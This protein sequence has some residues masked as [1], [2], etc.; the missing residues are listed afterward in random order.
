MKIHDLSGKK[1]SYGFIYV[2]SKDVKYYEMAKYSCQSLRDYYPDAHI[3]LFTHEK[4]LDGEEHGLFDSV[5]TDIPVHYRTKMWCM[6]R[7]PYEKTVYID[8]DSFV[9][10][11]DIRTIHNFLDE[12]DMFFTPVEAYTTANIKWAW[13][14]KQQTEVPKYHGAVCG[15]NKTDLNIDFMQTWYD[16]Y[17]KQVCD[18]EWPYEKNHYRE[19]KIFDMFTLWRMTCGK[20][21]EF[22]RFK[23]I[24]I[25]L[26][27]KRYNITAQHMAEEK[28]R[29]V[30]HQIDRDTLK[31]IPEFWNKIEMKE[32]NAIYIFK[33]SKIDKLPTEYN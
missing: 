21:E 6:A 27:H 23:N 4:F 29:T 2:A 19:W 33:Q 31:R 24:N 15:Y 18:P 12:C 28:I 26:L 3:T 8:A 16:E 20:W 5:I 9:C 22:D 14:D 17:I 10:H 25:N 13:I 7:T 11:K 1:S 32:N 30:I